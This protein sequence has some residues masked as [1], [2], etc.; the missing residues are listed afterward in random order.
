MKMGADKCSEAPNFRAIGIQVRK[1]KRLASCFHL[2]RINL[3]VDTA[4]AHSGS[5]LRVSKDGKLLQTASITKEY[6]TCSVAECRVITS[7]GSDAW[8][9][10]K[11]TRHTV[12]KHYELLQ[13]MLG[14]QDTAPHPLLNCQTVPLMV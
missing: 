14:I 11:M 3:Q 8:D 5:I 1:R 7:P 2:K 10:E 13:K 9:I 6:G 12:A 4:A